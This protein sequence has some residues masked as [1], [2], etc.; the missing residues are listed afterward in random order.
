MW[1]SQKFASQVKYVL[2]ISSRKV[3]VSTQ[4]SIRVSATVTAWNFGENCDD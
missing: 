4:K 2:C 3:V 1:Q